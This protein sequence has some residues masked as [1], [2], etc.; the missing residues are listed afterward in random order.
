M[1]SALSPVES[2]ADALVSERRLI[3]ELLAVIYRQRAAVADDD[4]QVIE[5][6]M[7]ATHRLLVTLSEAKRRRRTLNTLL[8]QPEDVGILALDRALG[9]R[10]TSELREAR[11]GLHQAARTL[12]R[13]VAVN[14]EL[15]RGA[16]GASTGDAVKSA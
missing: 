4:L 2:L 9:A 14:R 12:S 8:G 7:F 15:L 5:D 6:S 10:M 3:D 16:M 11:D 1:L 13:E